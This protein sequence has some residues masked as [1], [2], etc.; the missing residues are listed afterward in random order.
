MTRSRRPSACSP[1]C[2]AATSARRSSPHPETV[3]N[4]AGYL[5]PVEDY[6]VAHPYV[7]DPALL[8]VSP[9]ATVLVVADAYAAL[10]G[11]IYADPIL[12]R[13]YDYLAEPEPLSAKSEGLAEALARC[14]CSGGRLGVEPGLAADAH[15]G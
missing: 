1:R 15:G 3:A 11:G 7:S 10:V 6:P 4:L 13:S 9:T 2:G 14:G 12:A 5:E 8:V